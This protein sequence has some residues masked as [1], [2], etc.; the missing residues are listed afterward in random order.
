MG[1]PSW[2][3]IPRRNSQV[4]KFIIKFRRCLFSSPLKREIRHFHIVVVQKT[5]KEMYKKACCTFKVIVLLIK[6]IVFW[7]SRCRPRLWF[8][9]SLV[10]ISLPM[11]WYI[12]HYSEKGQETLLIICHFKRKRYLYFFLLYY[13]RLKFKSASMTFMTSL[14]KLNVILTRGQMHI[15]L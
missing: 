12:A 2:I 5:G 9:K 11:W 6:L 14:L 3:L 13:K 10:L 4:H 8:L 15:Q 1:E 7:R